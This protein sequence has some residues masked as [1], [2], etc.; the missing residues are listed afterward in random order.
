[1]GQLI[2]VN[3]RKARPKPSLFLLLATLTA[4]SLAYGAAKLAEAV[5]SIDIPS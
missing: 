2:H 5:L 1:M 3:F 4:L